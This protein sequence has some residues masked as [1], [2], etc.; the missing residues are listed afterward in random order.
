[1][2]LCRHAASAE[3]YTLS[4]HDALP[5]CRSAVL[6]GHRAGR[7]PRAGGSGRHRDR[8]STRLNSSHRGRSYADLRSISARAGRRDI[9]PLDDDIGIAATEVLQAQVQLAVADRDG[10]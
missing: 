10:V 5:I 9:E 6:E 2:V 3:V 8:K 7:C 1:M 4:L